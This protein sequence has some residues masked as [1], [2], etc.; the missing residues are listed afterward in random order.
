MPKGEI[1]ISKSDIVLLLT[2]LSNRGFNVTEEISQLYKSDQIPLNLLRK[3]NQYKPLDVLNFYEKLR[4][5]YNNKKSKLYINIMKSDEEQA[6]SP[7]SVLTTLSS[8]LNQILQFQCDDLVMFYDHARA[9]EITKVLKIYFD[10]YNI[11]P[12]KKLLSLF[13]ADIK[14]LEMIK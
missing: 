9:N 4:K 7:K 11:E 3:I 12:A 10:T 6:I 5:S 8:L 2:D 13:K 1:M 14:V